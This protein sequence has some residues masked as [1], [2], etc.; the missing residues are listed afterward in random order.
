MIR[1]RPGGLV[2]LIAPRPHPSVIKQR[3]SPPTFPLDFTPKRR[4]VRYYLALAVVLCVFG[5]T[6]LCFLWV[7]FYGL[8][9]RKWDGWSGAGAFLGLVYALAEYIT[10]IVQQPAPPSNLDPEECRLFFVK[11]LQVGMQDEEPQMTGSEA[12][13]SAGDVPSAREIQERLEDAIAL[14]QT[15]HLDTQ[16][17]HVHPHIQHQSAERGAPASSSGLRNR[18]RKPTGLDQTS[19]ASE[20][21]NNGVNSPMIRLRRLEKDDPRA[22]AFREKMRN[23]YVLS[24]VLLFAPLTL[25]SHLPRFGRV[26]WDSITRKDVLHWLA[27]SCC[28]LPYDTVARSPAQMALLEASVELLEARTGTTFTDFPPSSDATSS[29]TA[30]GGGE[31]TEVASRK[32]DMTTAEGKAHAKVRDIVKLMRFTMDPVNTRPRPLFIY[33]L[34]AFA[35]AQMLRT[36]YGNQLG[37]QLYREGDMDYL[38]RLPADWTPQKQD[39]EGCDPILFLHGL[40][41][42]LVSASRIPLFFTRLKPHG[43]PFIHDPLQ[44]QNKHVLETLVQRLPTN[45]IIVPLQPHVSMHVFHPRHLK[46]PGRDEMISTI[47]AICKRWDFWTD[48]DARRASGQ[49]REDR[50]AKV[51]RGEKVA[52]GALDTN[53]LPSSYLMSP[54]GRQPPSAH[55]RPIRRGIVLCSHSNGSIAHGW[56]VNDAPEMIL[57]NAFV[58][59]VVFCLWEGDVCYNFCYRKPRT[60]IEL[61]LHWFIAS[62]I[63]IANSIQRHFDWSSNTLFHDQIP[64]A[65]DPSKTLVV[66]GG[67]DVIIDS[68]RVKGY[69][70]RHGMHDSLDFDPLANHGEG[71]RG[72]SLERIVELFQR[73]D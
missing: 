3:A 49:Q 8:R 60:A 24:V 58:D 20:P 34:L 51:E 39:A 10:R 47:K 53:A 62:E 14:A 2:E 48:A 30:E 68:W 56:L 50:G 1:P 67:E 16:R 40:G 54:A 11:M 28:N 12:P 71:L 13:S 59:P 63:G 38:L 45:P 33:A 5:T 23:W 9:A 44:I 19:A 41:V 29:N 25:N 18:L 31:E 26:P 72:E 15:G 36:V 21:M 57:R 64:H 17:N 6:P 43:S 55:P 52:M 65:N 66:L 4:G 69:L 37:F 42:G 35:E 61:L 46:P 22:I 73:K 27:W 32:E 7:V 70:N